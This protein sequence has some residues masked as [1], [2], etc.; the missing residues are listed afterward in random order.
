MFKSQN[1]SFLKLHVKERCVI[2]ILYTFSTKI[3]LHVYHG[4]QVSSSQFVLDQIGRTKVNQY[5]VHK[6]VSIT[7]NSPS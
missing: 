3:K 6:L 7:D 2:F 5:G 4:G 1:N